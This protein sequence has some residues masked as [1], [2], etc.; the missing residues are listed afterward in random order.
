MW[1]NDPNYAESGPLAET[2]L[3]SSVHMPHVGYQGRLNGPVDNPISSCLSCHSTAEVPAGV[4]IPPRGT[5]PAPWFRNILAG[6]PFDAGRLGLDYSLQLA[7]GIS[8]FNA[9]AAVIKAS[10]PQ[11][12]GALIRRLQMI[13]GKPPRDGAP[14]D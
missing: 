10:S 8:N 11:A 7:V 12:R 6:Q 1:G 14:I 5:N 2:L 9:R 4:M 3:N 13:E